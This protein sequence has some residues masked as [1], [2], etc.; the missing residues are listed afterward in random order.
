MYYRQDIDGALED[1]IGKHGL[2]RIGLDRAMAELRPALDK[3]RHWHDS[4][5]FRDIYVLWLQRDQSEHQYRQQIDQ[6]PKVQFDDAGSA[7]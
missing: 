7:Q 3:I 1:A 5:S 4:D 6:S 2:P